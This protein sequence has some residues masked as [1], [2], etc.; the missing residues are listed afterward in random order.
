L[1]AKNAKSCFTAQNRATATA[2]GGYIFDQC[3]F[4]AAS[5]ATEELTQLVYL[6]RPYSQ[7]AKVIIKFSY[8]D[9]IIQPQGWKAWSA[10]DPRLDG[11]TFAEFQNQGPGNW[12][13]NTAA[14]VAFGNATLLASDTYTLSEVMATTSWIDMTYWNSIV[15]PQPAFI[16]PPVT[17]NSTS[18]VPGACIVSKSPITGLTTQSTIAKCI[19]LL[20]STSVVSTVFI[21]PGT[22]NEQLTFNR[23]GAT[24]FQG[25][26]GLRKKLLRII[27]YLIPGRGARN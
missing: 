21:Y 26:F 11:A 15:T 2:T 20:P 5:D 3:L 8:L 9:S 22:Y 18:P 1:A 6:G 12:E 16:P 25:T 17:G 7:F 14:R 27:L 4:T 24:I 10:T 13:N 23:S 19:S